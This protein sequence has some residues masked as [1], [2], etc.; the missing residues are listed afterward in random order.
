[1]QAKLREMQDSWLSRNADKMQKHVDAN[2]YKCFYDALKPL[3]GPQSK[4]TSLLLSADGSVLCVD[5]YA[6]LQ[7]WAEHF[8]SVLDRDGWMHSKVHHYGALISRR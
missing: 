7:R 1:M 6:I 3:Y 4:G 2:N 8:D 5:R